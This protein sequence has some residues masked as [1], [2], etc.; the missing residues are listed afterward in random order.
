MELNDKVAKSDF[1][2]ESESLAG[3]E[4]LAGDNVINDALN[5][6]VVLGYSAKEAEAVITNLNTS[7]EDNVE[8][9]LRKALRKLSKW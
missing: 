6:L 3:P 8:S 5:A 2:A 4:Q 7:E 1:V 9:L